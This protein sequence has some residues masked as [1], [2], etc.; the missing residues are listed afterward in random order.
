MDLMLTIYLLRAMEKAG[1]AS[2]PFAATLEKGEP[3][4]NVD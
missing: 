3:D 4:E 1:N 2:P